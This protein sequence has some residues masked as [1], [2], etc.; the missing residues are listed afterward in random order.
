MFTEHE[1]CQTA[2][3]KKTK[4]AAMWSGQPACQGL[5]M[6]RP[7][8]TDEET[9]VKGLVNFLNVPQEATEGIST[10]GYLAPEFNP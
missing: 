3:V 8:L 7:H 10:Q 5:I 1:C 9:G 2:R 4:I 6:Q